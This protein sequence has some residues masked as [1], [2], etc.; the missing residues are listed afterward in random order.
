VL[1]VLDGS[2][3]RYAW[4]YYALH[5]WRFPGLSAVPWLRQGLVLAAMLAGLAFSITGVAVAWRRL[6]QSL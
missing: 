1:T 3:K 6:R 2:R 5:T 4:V